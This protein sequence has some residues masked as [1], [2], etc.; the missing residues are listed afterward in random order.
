[1]S[2]WGFPIRSYGLKKRNGRL[3]GEMSFV[4]LEMDSGLESQ[5]QAAG[6]IRPFGACQ[7]G[8]WTGQSRP[9]VSADST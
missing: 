4:A 8:G 5:E 3:P 9:P 7:A 6:R 2:F 1:V